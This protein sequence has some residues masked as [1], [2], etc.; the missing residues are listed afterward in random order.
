MTNYFLGKHTLLLSIV[1]IFGALLVV[2]GCI[3]MLG[4]DPSIEP[5]KGVYYLPF[6]GA[7]DS[8]FYRIDDP[9]RRIRMRYCGRL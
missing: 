5:V 7:V 2:S 1:T 8:F 6:I 3:V 9:F 4:F